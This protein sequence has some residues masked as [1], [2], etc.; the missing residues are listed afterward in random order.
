MSNR[1]LGLLALIYALLLVYASVAVAPAGFDPL[2]L[3]FQ[4]ALA[5]FLAVHFVENGSDQRADWMANLTTLVPF[6]FLAS[7]ALAPPRPFEARVVAFLGSLVLC[8]GFVLSTKFAQCF[9]PRTVTLNYI[10][11]QS[12]GAAIGC[13][14]G[15]CLGR[16]LAVQH[17]GSNLLLPLLGAYTLGIVALMLMPFDVV[18]STQD[19]AERLATLRHDLFSL[20]GAGMS[21][22]IRAAWLTTSLAACM[23]VGIFLRLWRPATPLLLSATMLMGAVMLLS[24]LIMGSA[25]SLLNLPLDVA[26]A[27]AGGL[28]L[29]WMQR[30]DIDALRR[31]L[32]PAV[33][34]AVPLYIATLLVVN[35]LTSPGWR[36]PAEALVALDPRQLLPLWTHYIVSKAHAARSIAAHLAMY[37]PVGLLIWLCGRKGALWSWGVAAPLAFLLSTGIEVGRWLRPGQQPDFNNNVIGAVAAGAT[38]MLMPRIWNAL[39]ALQENGDRSRRI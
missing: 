11:A 29:G 6:G 18:L 38:A 31:A 3:S 37:A 15:A 34:I 36:T 32:V 2:G 12:A 10:V 21:P 14:L 16:R 19:L 22:P 8:V 25:P 20:P 23:P 17:W 24:M 26:G 27:L 35:G 7:A 1:R 4:Q 39:R 13:A 9:F 30:H 5:R 28:A 33:W